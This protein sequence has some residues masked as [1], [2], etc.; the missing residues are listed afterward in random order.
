MIREVATSSEDDA[1][2]GTRDDLPPLLVSHEGTN[3]GEDGVGRGRWSREEGTD[4][5]NNAGK[6]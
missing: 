3:G 5:G 4:L 1:E 2:Q 6:E